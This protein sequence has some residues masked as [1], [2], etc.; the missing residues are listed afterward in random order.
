MKGKLNLVLCKEILNFM[1]ESKYE[2]DKDFFCNKDYFLTCYIKEDE[3]YSDLLKN[4]DYINNYIVESHE[5]FEETE[6]D[7]K[8]DFEI[9]IINKIKEEN[10]DLIE[11]CDEIVISTSDDQDDEMIASYIKNNEKLT[12]KKVIIG[13]NYALSDY[14]KLKSLFEGI[15]NIYFNIDGNNQL[16]KLEDFEKTFKYIDEL[17]NKIKRYN[18]SPLEQVM[19]AYDLVRNR[20]YKM[21]DDGEDYNTSRDLTSVIT[22]DKIVC[23]GFSNIFEQVLLRLGLKTKQDYIMDAN[24]NTIGH[25]RN[26]VYIN[27]S[28]YDVNGIYYFDVTWDSKND[29]FDVSYLDS[30]RFFAK[31]KKEIDMCSGNKY[32]S[33]TFKCLDD[34]LFFDTVD[35]LE[36][37]QFELIS[38]DQIKT[39]NTLYRFIEGK[40]EMDDFLID[41]RITSKIDFFVEDAKKTINDNKEKIINTLYEYSAFFDRAINADI[42]LKVLYNVR[43]NEYYENSDKYPFDLINFIRIINESGWIFS[44]DFEGRLLRDILGRVPK[45]GLANKYIYNYASKNEL[46]KQINQVKL[47]KV[48]SKIRDKRSR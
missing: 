22:G 47:T 32:V 13:K 27:D 18:Y 8:D 46:D 42:L 21:E 29:L 1:L 43:K 3:L 36:E 19:Y 25:V 14:L 26:L 9:M 15:P 24:D 5:F 45:Y 12:E 16:I 2:V 41:F 23:V 35:N 40:E 37:N 10:F 34:D 44:E 11:N 6:E 31:T 33:R 30:Y 7:I 4:K 39:I 20:V 48:L 38:K 28:K 17:A